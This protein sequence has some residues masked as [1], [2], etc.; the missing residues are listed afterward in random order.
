[1]GDVILLVVGCN[2]VDWIERAPPPDVSALLQLPAGAVVDSAGCV[3]TPKTQGFTCVITADAP[4]GM[5]AGADEAATDFATWPEVAWDRVPGRIQYAWARDRENVGLAVH[6]MG[7]GSRWSWSYTWGDYPPPYQPPAV[8]VDPAAAWPPLL[9][10]VPR[11]ADAVLHTAT[12][13]PVRPMAVFR[14]AA[15]PDE[16]IAQLRAWG[17]AAVR[18]ESRGVGTRGAMVA[19]D[20]REYALAGRSDGDAWQWT[21]TTWPMP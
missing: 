15:P 6:E 8:P 20:G 10:P 17:G 4:V 16:V 14:S 1:V 13:D 12:T 18:L 11:P 2:P 21:L 9:A 5:Q 7:A 19:R 3:G